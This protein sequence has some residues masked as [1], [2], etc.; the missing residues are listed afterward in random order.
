MHYNKTRNK[1]TIGILGGMG[2]LASANL[3]HVIIKTAQT[4][5]HA[6][7]DTDF[8]PM[9][10][11]NLPLF[12]FD[13]TG[14]VNPA[15]VRHQ[16]IA[17]VKKLESAGSDCIIIACNT[18]HHFYQD[19]QQAITIPIISMIEETA[20]TVKEKGYTVVGLLSSESTKTLGIYSKT[21]NHY[22]IKTLS[23]TTPQQQLLNKIILH[24]MSG[25]H[26]ANDK[27]LLTQI[28][29]SLH[30]QGAQSIILGCTELPL[31]ISQMDVYTTLFNSIE[32]IVQSAL[33]YVYK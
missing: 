20:K 1:K 33:R 7:Q 8:P 3:Y 25:V 14:F 31:A 13:E 18:V 11:Y 27:K 32:I 10:I 2:P 12:G 22:D 16:L 26:G 29:D 30:T 24:V 15:L 19:M 5:Y 6:E 21:L 23:V 17:G 4:L 9:F 28:I